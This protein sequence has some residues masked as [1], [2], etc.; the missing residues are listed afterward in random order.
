Q[1]GVL[2]RGDAA[3]QGLELMRH[4]LEVLGVR[5]LARVHPL[6]VT[7]AT[8]LDL[9]DVG[10]GLGLLHGEVVDDDAGVAYAVQHHSVLAREDVQL[11]HLGQVGAAVAQLRDLGVDLLDVEQFQL[12]V[13]IGFQRNLLIRHG[14]G[15]PVTSIVHGSVHRVL[16]RVSTVASHY[17]VSLAATTGSQVHSAAQWATSIR[18]GPSFSRNSEA[19]WW[20]R[21]DVT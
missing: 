21:S 7:E 11:A 13:R 6:P 9:L 14:T 3:L 18:A 4:P 17:A 1:L 5:H 12:G 16:T 15:Q 8:S 20:R 2:E 19:G 10:V